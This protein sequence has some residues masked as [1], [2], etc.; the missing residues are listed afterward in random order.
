MQERAEGL[1][2]LWDRHREAGGSVLMLALTAPHDFGQDLEPLRRRVARAW[3]RVIAGAPWVRW[4]LKTKCVGFVRALEV[5][6][7]RNGWHPHLHVLAYFEGK[8]PPALEVQEWFFHRWSKAFTRGAPELRY[9]SPEHG[10][11]VTSPRVGDYLA[12]MGLSAELALSHTKAGRKHNRTPW[13]ILRDYALAREGSP[14]RAR[15]RELWREWTDAM[16]GARQLTV[17]RELRRRYAAAAQCELELSPDG[18]P[19]DP[20]AWEVASWSS[21]EWTEICHRDRRGAWRVAALSLWRYARGSWRS[22]LLRWECELLGR[23]YPPEHGS[24]ND[25]AGTE[26]NPPPQL[27]LELERAA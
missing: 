24:G 10:V 27:S 19:A 9:P 11:R 21:A 25:N 8:A 12:K 15:D 7:G 13:Q 14:A 4:K 18:S 22:L 5:T 20:D 6:H 16:R 23:P 2:A 26:S 1:R 17:S 3:Q